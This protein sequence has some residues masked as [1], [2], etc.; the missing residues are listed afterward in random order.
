MALVDLHYVDTGPLAAPERLEAR[1]PLVLIHGIG[2]S[3]RD[4][5]YVTPHFA[6]QRRVIAPDLRGYGASPR[7]PDYRPTSL[8]ADVWALLERLGVARFDLLGH[9]M[10][11]AIALQMAVDRP[12]RLRRAV[13]ADTLPS[14]ETNSRAKKLLFWSRLALMLALGPMPLT[15]FLERRA[16]PG[17]AAAALCQRLIAHGGGSYSRFVYVRTLWSL[18]DWHVD[19][20][21][22]RVVC[23][24][25]VLVAERD[26][27]P[28]ADA[29]RFAAVLPEGQL[30]VVPDAGHQLPLE[31]PEAFAT[32]VLGFLDV[33]ES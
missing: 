23:P 13:F 10:G 4:F 14:F 28:L 12:E 22:E 33:T 18:R 17:D 30:Q 15:R 29:K 25:L 21:L 9:S 5:E 31:V 1:P 16:H 24:A 27:F 6:R 3:A 19:E 7:G 32:R 11:G 8:A 2:A 20:R 26:Y